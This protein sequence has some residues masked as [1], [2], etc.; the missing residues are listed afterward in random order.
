[1]FTI[2][3]TLVFG[4][5]QGIAEFL[6]ISSSAH[7]VLVPY[8]FNWQ[9]RG[10]EFDVALHFG[11]AIAVIAFFWRDWVKIFHNA[12][13]PKSA[14]DETYP[15]NLLWQI[16]VATIPAAIA[17]MILS[18]YIEDCF[19]SPLLLA[20]NLAVFGLLLW[21]VDLK[22]GKEKQTANISFANSLLVGF[23]QVFAL[24]PGVSRSGITVLAARSL[25]LPREKAAR[26]S[27][28]IGTPATLGAFLVEF[29][30]IFKTH[31][32]LEFFLGI[33]VSAITGY[34]AIKYLLAYLAKSD[35]KIFFIYRLLLA[36]IVILIFLARL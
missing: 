21:L 30:K 11:T 13:S 15:K 33:I 4:I 16:V 14:T 6:P 29:P 19:H 26:F 24:I 32:G 2:I 7:L 10:L 34:L 9:Y 36:V 3:Q 12:F 25:G 23:A 8:L 28:L 18:S 5:I 27:F 17:G 22:A 20:I 1:M 31:L 35:F